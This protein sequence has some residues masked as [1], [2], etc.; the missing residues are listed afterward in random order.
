M[1]AYTK[2]VTFRLYYKN[3]MDK[4]RQ[5]RKDTEVKLKD[6][7]DKNQNIYNT[8]CENVGHYINDTGIDF[9]KYVEFRENVY[10]TGEFFKVVKGIMINKEED[11]K[12]IGTN[13]DLYQL[14]D[15]Q[16]QIHDAEKELEFINR[17][18]DLTI[19]D[20]NK[21]LKLYYGEV[22]KK[23]IV[24]GYG[25]C[26]PGHIGYICVIRYKVVNKTKKVIDYI[27]TKKNKERLLA[28]GKTLYN[29]DDAAYYKNHGL[30]YNGVDYRIYKN[31]EYLYSFGLVNVNGMK[32]N[33][34]LKF[35][36]A[37]TRGAEVRGKTNDDLYNE[38]EGDINKI[39]QLNVDMKTKLALCL[40]ADSILYTKF[41]RN[42]SQQT[43]AYDKAVSKGR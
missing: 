30:E 15:T 39:M 26:L 12:L 14:A 20:Y 34:A 6:L 43:R 4:Y 9:N 5:K 10:S 25:Y 19:F 24:D 35:L 41:I 38:C 29:K 40:K 8:I 31:D 2:P 3:L 32:N 27:A 33:S 11:Y 28:E 18:L 23:L 36:V 17:I 1:K 22:Q 13:Y 37:D 7:I 16:K 42:E 21:I